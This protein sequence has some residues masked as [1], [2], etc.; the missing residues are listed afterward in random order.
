MGS[1]S[2]KQRRKLYVPINCKDFRTDCFRAH[3]KLGTEKALTYILMENGICDS[4]FSNTYRNYLSPKNKN[5]IDKNYMTDGLERPGYL[6]ESVY[7]KIIEIFK[8]Q[9]KYRL[10]KRSEYTAPKI[11]AVPL[12]TNDTSISDIANQLKEINVSINRLGNVMM[13]I[14]EKMPAKTIDRPVAKLPEKK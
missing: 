8:M 3:S 6:Q 7:T 5:W 11:N 13:Q 12:N 4:V 14:L 9:D 10:V 1:L 2:E